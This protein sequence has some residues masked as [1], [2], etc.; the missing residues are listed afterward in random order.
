M[1]FGGCKLLFK[2]LVIILSFYV[3]LKSAGKVKST[4]FQECWEIPVPEKV[5]IEN[6]TEP[7]CEVIEG[8]N[9]RGEVHFTTGESV[10]RTHQVPIPSFYKKISFSNLQNTG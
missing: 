8:T 6:C 9:F 7:P 10:S 2:S 3:R 5:I 1:Y 4:P